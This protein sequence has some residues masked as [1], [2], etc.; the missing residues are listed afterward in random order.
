[1]WNKLRRSVDFAR[2]VIFMSVE[3]HGYLAGIDEKKLAAKLV[4]IYSSYRESLIDN[5]CI[6]LNFQVKNEKVYRES[7]GYIYI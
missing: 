3:K 6:Q 4:S 5:I 7:T 2:H 1:M